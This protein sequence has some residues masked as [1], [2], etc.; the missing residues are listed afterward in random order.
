MLLIDI[1]FSLVCVT[2]VWFFTKLFWL[3]LNAT[4]ARNDREPVATVTFKHKVALEK[5]SKVAVAAKSRRKAQAAGA[6]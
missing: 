4:T 3:D 5:G 6:I 1:P 2:A